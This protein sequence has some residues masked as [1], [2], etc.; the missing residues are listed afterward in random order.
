MDILRSRM[1]SARALA[2]GPLGKS[3]NSNIENKENSQQEVKACHPN[4]P[5][6]AGSPHVRRNLMSSYPSGDT[7]GTNEPI[8]R[9][10]PVQ[11]GSCITARRRFGRTQRGQDPLSYRIGTLTFHTFRAM[12]PDNGCICRPS[13]FPRCSRPCKRVLEMRRENYLNSLRL[14]HMPEEHRRKMI[15]Q[16][17]PVVV[18]ICR[19]QKY[20]AK[21]I[22]EKTEQNQQHVFEEMRQMDSIVRMMK[23]TR[24]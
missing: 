21:F 19:A 20:N 12:D 3:Q 8:I 16:R 11:V 13:P 6:R 24:F 1:H 18:L 17:D 4:Q 5:S 22:T 9:P 15:G 23:E 2:N 7:S 10:Q 14:I